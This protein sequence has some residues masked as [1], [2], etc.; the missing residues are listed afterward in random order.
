LKTLASRLT[1]AN[2][3]ATLALFLVLSGG[4]AY[5]ASHL[6][7]NSVGTRQLK[8]G[9]ISTAKLKNG[10]V[11]AA[12]IAAGVIPQVQA[13]TAPPTKIDPSSLGTV[14]DATHADTAGNAEQL[15]GAPPSTYRDSCPGGTVPVVAGLCVTPQSIGIFSFFP[16]LRACAKLG[17]Q[18]PN[19]TEAVLIGER[20]VTREFWSDDYWR[21]EGV[22][23]TLSWFQPPISEVVA[24]S[25]NSNG[26]TY[27]VGTATDQ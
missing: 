3:V 10:A 7:K 16:A 14:P 22:G 4:A 17:L 27:C 21:E 6:G 15:G 12:K 1:Y 23:F 5:A 13:G 9:S 26:D 8:K 19:P 11:T 24:A 20:F 18:L 2:V 25:T